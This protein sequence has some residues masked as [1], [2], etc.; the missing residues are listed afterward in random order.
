MK[1]LSF[2]IALMFVAFCANAQDNIVFKD[3]T[4]VKAKVQEITTTEVVYKRHDNMAGPVYRIERNKVFIIQFENGTSEV[5]TPVNFNQVPTATENGSHRLVGNPYRS[6]GLSFLF[7][8]LLPGGGQYYNHQ[9]GKGAAMSALWMGGIITAA[10]SSRRGNYYESDCH[11]D[12]NGVYTCTDYRNYN[13]RGSEAQATIGMVAFYG[14]WIWSMIDAPVS[15]ARINR[16]NA[17]G[18]TS[19]MHFNVGHKASLRFQPFRSQG[20]GGSLSVNF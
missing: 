3:G 7:S 8:F 15:S 2:A 1:S 20:L 12:A 5:V 4:E 19:M 17:N 9:Y 13:H 11:F 14:S 6:P 16:R 10:T 18:L